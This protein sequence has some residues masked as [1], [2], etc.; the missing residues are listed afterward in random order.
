ML[1]ILV[2]GFHEDTGKVVDGTVLIDCE[3]DRDA[4]RKALDWLAS[5]APDEAGGWQ[6]YELLDHW[7]PGRQ[8]N[9]IDSDYR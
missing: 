8:I 5:D 9:P 2:L 4:C 6:A 7:G 3:N 1:N